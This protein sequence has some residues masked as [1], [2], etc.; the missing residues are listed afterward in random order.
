[1]VA[2]RLRRATEEQPVETGCLPF[3]LVARAFLRALSK[4][5]FSINLI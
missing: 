4:C 5:I 2:L 1:M 3:F